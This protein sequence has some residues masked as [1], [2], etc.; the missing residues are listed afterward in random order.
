MLPTKSSPL[1]CLSGVVMIGLTT[2][3]KSTFGI[4]HMPQNSRFLDRFL[5]F[6]PSHFLKLFPLVH[7][8]RCFPFAFAITQLFTHGS[9]VG[10]EVQGGRSHLRFKGH[11][12]LL[13][14]C[15]QK[16]GKKPKSSILTGFSIIFTIHF[17]TPLFLVQHPYTLQGTNP[18]PS[19][20]QRN[21]STQVGAGCLGDI[22]VPRRVNLLRWEL[23]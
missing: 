15:F 14:G 6:S 19:L 3:C 12:Y 11:Y 16:Y 21:S 13:Y 1:R 18:Y 8:F 7:L 10:S 4:V 23:W 9:Q 2:H 20:G 22:L 17:G 5:T